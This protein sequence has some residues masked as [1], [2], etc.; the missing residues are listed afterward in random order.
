MRRDQL[1]EEQWEQ[2]QDLLPKNGRRGGQWKDHGR[3]LNGIFWILR[4]GAPWWDL[5]ERYG[6]WHTVYDRFH[7][8]QT[9]GLFDPPPDPWVR[10][11]HPSQED[12]QKSEIS[13]TPPRSGTRSR[14]STKRKR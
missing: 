7:R 14:S 12:T 9:D 5:P 10:R 8:R 3:I 6:R 1:S 11:D 2:L 13:L 4:T